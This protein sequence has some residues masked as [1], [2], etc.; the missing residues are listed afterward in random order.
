MFRKTKEL[1]KRIAALEKF[2]G[3]PATYSQ[4]IGEVLGISDQYDS[5][6]YDEECHRP[7]LRTMV[8]L[9][10][11]HLG[12]EFKYDHGQN[13]SFKIKTKNDE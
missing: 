2:I 9:I 12:L 3:Y 1:E 6:S 11:K 4:T 8:Q 13:A 7:G 5:Y 10:C